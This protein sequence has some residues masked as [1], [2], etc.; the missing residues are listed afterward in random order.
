MPG[1]DALM[2][3]DLTGGLFEAHPIPVAVI[4]AALSL[5]SVVYLLYTVLRPR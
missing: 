3:F 2:F 1:Q 4:V 5:G